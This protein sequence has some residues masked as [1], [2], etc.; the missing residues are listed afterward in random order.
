MT[1]H[2]P[3]HAVAHG[4]QAVV[5]LYPWSVLWILLA[6]M[7]VLVVEGSWTALGAVSLLVLIVTLHSI[8]FDRAENRKPR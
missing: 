8:H 6:L 7:A 1:H 3:A 4:L 2:N 5:G